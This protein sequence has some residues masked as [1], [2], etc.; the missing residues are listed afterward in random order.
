VTRCST[1]A[2]LTR[3][4]DTTTARLDDHY[5]DCFTYGI[6]AEFGIPVLCVGDDFARTDVDVL[7]PA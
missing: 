1:P 6:A 2:P 5:G 7:R 3:S 4:S